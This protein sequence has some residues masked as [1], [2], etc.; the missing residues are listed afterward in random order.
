MIICTY[1]GVWP[2]RRPDLTHLNAEGNRR[3]AAEIK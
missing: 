1:A 2:E 3:L